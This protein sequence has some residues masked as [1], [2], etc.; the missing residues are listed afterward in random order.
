MA[1][2]DAE[3]GVPRVEDPV[4]DRLLAVYRRVRVPGA[5]AALLGNL[6]LTFAFDWMFG[7][8]AVAAAV[9]ALAD[10]LRERR[11][12]RRSATGT[13]V[14][15]AT[16]LGLTMVAVGLP[17]VS[18]AFG[19]WI[20]I[21][22]AAFV[23]G[24]RRLLLYGYVA[25]WAV[26]A[27]LVTWSGDR[28][29]TPHEVV[30]LDWT[31]LLLVGALVIT[32]L[33][34]ALQRI[35]A[36][37]AERTYMMG[38]V[39]HELG[40]ALGSVVANASTVERHIAEL[41]EHE[42]AELLTAVRSQAEESADI[43]EDLLTL[44]RLQNDVLVVHPEVVNLVAI[45]EA[46]L[47]RSETAAEFIG[48]HAL[49]ARVDPLRY[50]QIVRNLLINAARHGGE[51]IVIELTATGE[52]TSLIVRD[53]GPGIPDERLTDLL[54]DPGP[55]SSARLGLWVSRRLAEEM[56]GTLGY[57]RDGNWTAFEVGLPAAV[58]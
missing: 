54:D 6:A 18:F 5:L 28:E 15:D 29:W 52:R 53:D 49:S 32:L 20:V 44:A 56:G 35:R 3:P 11:S 8:L 41:S 51:R 10:A 33:E 46:V 14:V 24:L 48:P 16:L 40:N 34:V 55:P 17:A 23:S 45:T 31:A 27:N 12:Q 58:E 43:A 38:V 57:R 2:Q 1:R 36:M 50:R 47:R 22:T 13:I 30:V 26:L 21:L 9:V 4:I 39:G 42:V 37:E 19:L 7:W 25:L